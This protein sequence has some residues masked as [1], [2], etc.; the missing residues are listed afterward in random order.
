MNRTLLA[1]L[2]AIAAAASMN[3][4]SIVYSDFSSTAG[5]VLN[6]GDGAPATVVDNQLQLAL[7]GNVNE[8][9]SV[10]YQNQIYLQNGFTATFEYQIVSPGADGFAFLV[11]NSPA[12]TGAI[13]GDG[14]RLGFAGITNSLAVDFDTWTSNGSDIVSCGAGANQSPQSGAGTCAVDLHIANPTIRNGQVNTATITYDP[15]T[16]KLSLSINNGQ[17]GGTA[18]LPT[19]IGTFLGLNDGSGYVGF[20]AGNGAST[21]T[22]R[23]LNLDVE[24]GSAAPEPATIALAAAGILG[25]ALRRRRKN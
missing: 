8:S 20:T 15:A 4:D 18:T 22:V 21:Q 12:G 10:W 14:G 19:D 25:V 6:N 24:T 3:A 7:A 9:N 13:G 23:I 5:L 1:G 11:Q 17:Y 16:L 2:L